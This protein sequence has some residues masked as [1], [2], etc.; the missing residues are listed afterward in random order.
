[1]QALQVIELFAG[2]QPSGV[3]VVERLGVKVL[4][5]NSCQ[6]VQSPVF[7]KGIASGDIIRL[8]AKDKVEQ[9]SQ[10]LYRHF[11]LVRRSGNLC[12]RVYSRDDIVAL[13]DELTP[14]LEKLGGELDKEGERFLIFSIHVSCGFEAIEKALNGAMEKFSNSQWLYGNVYDPEDGQT[15]LNWWQEFLQ[16][17]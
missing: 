17:E 8:E 5:D 15:P 10:A 3:P 6:L 12:I 11:S 7:I 9:S 1:M 16:P 4:E 14:T 13:S 2:L